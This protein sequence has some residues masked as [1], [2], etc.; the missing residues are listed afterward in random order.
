MNDERAELVKF[1][2]VSRNILEDRILALVRVLD[3]AEEL[4][5]ADDAAQ[6]SDDPDADERYERAWEQLRATLKTP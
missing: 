5:A 1:D 2:G 6:V 4:V 3:A